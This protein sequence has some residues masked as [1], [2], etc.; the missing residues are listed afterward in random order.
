MLLDLR[1]A[2]RTIT[3]HAGASIAMVLSLAVGLALNTSVFAWIDAVVLDPLP[4]AD[5]SRLVAIWG[6]P[7]F[8][9]RRGMNGADLDEWASQSRTIESAASFQLTPFE[10]TA[11]GSD[12]VA[13]GFYVGRRMMALLGVQP[14]LGRDFSD[15]ENGLR[16]VLI[17][18][19]W[20]QARF[21][22]AP[23]AIGA[24]V[25]IDGEPRVI[26]G[27]MPRGFYFPDARSRLWAVLKQEGQVQ[28]A[29]R[30]RAGAGID[31]VRAEL[32]AVLRQTPPPD[33]RSSV[34][35]P[36]GVFWLRRLVVDDYE[37]ASWALWGASW[38]LLLA[39][40]ANVSSVLVA[41]AV[42]QARHLAVRRALGA[43]IW[44]I[45]RLPI[46][47][48]LLL[49]AAS[50]VAGL[51]AA[52]MSL[53]ALRLLDL[54]AMPAVADAHVNLRVLAYGAGLA[55]AMGAIAGLVPT[56]LSRRQSILAV[57]RNGDA[58]SGSRRAGQLRQLMVWAEVGVAM[59]LVVSAG[60]L[61]QSFVRLARVDW[62]FEPGNLVVATVTLPPRMAGQPDARTRFAE[63]VL[64]RV[65]SG[66]PFA[67]SAA[68]AHAMP[69]GLNQWSPS[70]ILAD[71][72][73][74][75]A[76]L[77]TVSERYFST[78]GIPLT[79]GREFA[80]D[81]HR[82]PERAA[83][84]D[85]R[86]AQMAWPGELAIGK[87]FTLLR[88]TEAVQRKYARDR[89]IVLDRRLMSDPRSYELDGAPW[90]VIGQVPE[91]RMFGLTDRSSPAAYLHY[92]QF[93]R[94]LPVLRQAFMV[95]STGSTHH[96][97]I[98]DTLRAV[99]R[100]AEP[101]ARVE[102]TEGHELVAAVT[103]R[104]GSRPLLTALSGVLGGLALTVG[105]IG[106]FGIASLTTTRRLKELA[107]RRTL[108]A[109]TLQLVTSVYG[110]QL[111]VVGLGILAGAAG[112]FAL[113]QPLRSFLFGVPAAD[114][115]TYVLAAAATLLVTAIAAGPP[116]GRALRT[117]P[118]DALRQD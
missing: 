98:A 44:R 16:E 104:R 115:P 33:R 61:I 2:L 46:A 58:G 103:G 34:H 89:R 20:W 11:G 114:P 6:T 87:Q 111:R 59:T 36:A 42:D 92:R 30:L 62:G 1:F 22:G 17:S 118:A 53:R 85:A 51:F 37:S 101:A 86:F 63:E 60:L 35:G 74:W 8:S 93:D 9:E 18:N 28:M 41:R 12:E 14:A 91:V 23:S 112:A 3:A 108:G 76:G 88:F 56:M 38:L 99:V 49:A 84:V 79:H 69:L 109:T 73:V 77:W 50:G 39:A 24:T 113:S 68:T 48:A 80:V 83:I 52:S 105:A 26:V 55:L 110:L 81:Q 4:Y 75:T 43:S 66:V 47:E 106:V 94:P 117:N 29:A 45:A 31:Q 27:V 64:A 96:Q 82:R 72:R 25:A 57:L 71:D 19:E 100:S 70:V 65:S 97:A 78:L 21:A 32:S 67:K 15:D 116:L 40:C 95:R 7:S 13:R 10:V 5:A 107:I 102:L 90:V 54:S